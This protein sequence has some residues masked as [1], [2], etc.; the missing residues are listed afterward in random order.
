MLVDVHTHYWKREHWS[1]EMEREASIARG[2][3]AE[4]DIQEEDHWAAMG[5][6]DKAF[7]FGFRAVHSGLVVPNALVADYVA[8]HP[9]RS[10]DVV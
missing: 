9:D 8:R 3:P 10:E 2:F 6:V 5:A 1:E 4:V 7:V